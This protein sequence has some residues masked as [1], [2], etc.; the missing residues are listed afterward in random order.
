MVLDGPLPKPQVNMCLKAF[1]L[2]NRPFYIVHLRGPPRWLQCYQKVSGQAKGGTGV[3]SHLLV[4]PRPFKFIPILLLR[5]LMFR[6]HQ[7]PLTPS[8]PQKGGL[9]ESMGCSPC[10]FPPAWGMAGEGQ[11]AERF[12]RS[13]MRRQ[14]P[15]KGLIFALQD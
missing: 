13:L 7:Y 11:S 3:L 10:A 14:G 15:R 4:L 8:P 6:I 9:G 12:P 2:Q 5:L 1:V